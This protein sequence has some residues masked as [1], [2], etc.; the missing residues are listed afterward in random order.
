[1]CGC[2][3]CIYAKS[4]HSSLLSWRYRYLEKLKD[5]IQN[6]QN[7]RSGGKVNCIYETYKNTFMPHRRHINAKSYDM[8]KAKMCANHSLIMRYHP[9]NVYCDVVPNVL[10]LRFLTRK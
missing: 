7:R 6:A 4:V 10:A 9:G 3:C 8:A 2:E 1:M 5:L